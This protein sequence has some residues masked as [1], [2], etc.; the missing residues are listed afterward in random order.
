[1]KKL[2]ILFG[3]F[4][5]L[6]IPVNATKYTIVINGFSYSPAL[7]TAHI[8]DTITIEASTFHP[9]V[10]V[11]EATW[12]SD[13]TTP[14][15]GGWGIKTS[16]YTFTATKAETL[17]FV[18]EVHVTFGLKGRVT[19]VPSSG[20]SEPS[21][22]QL[23]VLVYPN[24]MTSTGTIRLSSYGTNPVSVMVFGINGQLEKDL[25][26][27]PFNLNGESYYQFDASTL[28]GGNHFVLV[29]DGQKKVVRKIEVIR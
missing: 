10:Q 6:T 26:S 16:S 12:N 3:V 15:T 23:V 24:P 25:S 2:V 13:G 4:A 20:I 28:S 1:M 29:S 7:V 14:L 22:N 27:S 11:S 8:G 9:L 19:I 18:C 21:A 17:Y 5:A